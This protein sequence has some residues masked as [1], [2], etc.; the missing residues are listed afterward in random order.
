[1]SRKNQYDNDQMFE[2]PSSGYYFPP[3]FRFPSEDERGMMDMDSPMPGPMP[4]DMEDDMIPQFP[5]GLP[6]GMPS[7]SEFAGEPV[8]IE[9]PL[10]NIAYLQAYLR[11]NIGKPVRVEFLLG[12]SI[13][14]DKTGT[15]E[16][17]GI[18]Y[19]VLRDFGGTKVVCDLYSIKFVNIFDRGMVGVQR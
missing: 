6:G 18:S 13:L 4:Q 7:P 9:P 12:T 17:V 10:T 5:T 14:E 11:Q 3:M 1:M 16:D 2:E 8:P 15:L 19:I